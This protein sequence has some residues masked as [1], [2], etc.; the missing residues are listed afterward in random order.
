MNMRKYIHLVLAGGLLLSATAFAAPH[1]S[2]TKIPDKLTVCT[3][4]ADAKKLE[5]TA[6]TS[7]INK[8]V[9]VG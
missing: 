8:C 4:Q 1:K 5:G 3:Q 6:R 7:F 9:K 2:K